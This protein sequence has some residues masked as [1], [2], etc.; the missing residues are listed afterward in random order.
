MVISNP[1]NSNRQFSFS[2]QLFAQKAA[3]SIAEIQNG[4]NTATETKIF[5]EVLGYDDEIAITNGFSSLDDLVEYIQDFGDFFDLSVEQDNTRIIRSQTLANAPSAQKRLVEAIMI[6][7]PWL[8]ALVLLH[9]TGFSLWMVRNLAVP[10][11]TAFVSGIYL[12]IIFTEGFAQTFTSL[13]SLA[14][15]Q[16]NI[17]EM[18][19]VV[20]R[21]YFSIG[22][23]IIGLSCM[24]FIIGV[25]IDLPTPLITIAI[26]SMASIAI[27][28]INYV[29]FYALRKNR[30]LFISYLITIIVLISSYVVLIRNDE[31]ISNDSFIIYLVSLGVAFSAFSGFTFFYIYKT[32]RSLSTIDKTELLPSFYKS[33]II[34]NTLRSRFAVQFWETFPYFLFGTFYFLLIFGDRIIAWIFNPD[35]FI[36]PNGSLLPFAFNSAYHV[37]A[38]PSLLFVL[39]P[40]MIVQYVIMSKIHFSVHQTMAYLKILEIDQVNKVIRSNYRMTMV[41]SLVAATVASIILNVVGVEV[42]FSTRI[43]D[44]SLLILQYASI[45]NIFLS[46]FTANHVILISLNKAKMGSL[47]TVAGVA[48]ILFGGIFVGGYD[49]SYI[50]FAYLAATIVLAVL[51]TLYAVALLR[52]AAIRF[53]GRYS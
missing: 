45:A 3:R 11:T 51:S 22:F 41:L 25:I 34:P 26:F 10:I 52:N 43:S 16:R 20:Q 8:T 15:E 48:I 27:Q 29:I 35:I 19:R 44:K 53:L 37:G 2:S 17:G 47:L 40:A 14:Y 38:D 6:Y 28:R 18:K 42:L 12:G 33:T 50:I 21:M 30:D 39:T 1:L 24:I 4:A 32:I 5:L 9:V 7:F 46:I 31:I 36:M 49:Y 23:M 13:L